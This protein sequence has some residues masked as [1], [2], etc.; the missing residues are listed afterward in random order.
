MFLTLSLNS[1]F[2][3]DPVKS[4]K[5]LA[6]LKSLIYDEETALTQTCLRF[7]FFTICL[8]KETEEKLIRMETY[9]TPYLYEI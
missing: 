6:P 2:S 9:E 8:E 5:I 7:L 4:S 3:F 1:A